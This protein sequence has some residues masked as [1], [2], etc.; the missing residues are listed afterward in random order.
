MVGAASAVV[1]SALLVDGVAVVL[2]NKIIGI[3]MIKLSEALG[4]PMISALLMTCVVILFHVG[5]DP[6]PGLAPLLLDVG[7]GFVTYLIGVIACRRIFGYTAG[8][9]LTGRIL[10]GPAGATTV[11]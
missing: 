10:R 2:T 3:P 5:L 8:G 1:V 4:Y 6:Q 9:I 11:L 7:L